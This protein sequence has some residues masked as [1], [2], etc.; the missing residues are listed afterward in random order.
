M[1]N[2]R[3]NMRKFVIMLLSLCLLLCAAGCKNEPAVPSTEPS[4][5]QPVQTQ[6]PE[7]T[8]ETQPPMIIDLPLAAFSA[9][10]RTQSHYANDG[11]LL[12]TYAYQDFSLILEDPQVADAIVIDLLNYVDYE[13]DSIKGVLSDAEA[14]YNTATDFTPFTY[15]SFF[16]PERFDQSILSLYGVNA[17]H[18]GS[19]RTA[20]S[21]ISVTYD[22]L[23]GRQLTLKDILSED[24]SADTLS[25][26]LIDALQPMSE[27]GLL[28]SDYA[29]VVS[30]LFST[31]RPVD[32]WYL[33]NEALCFFFAPYEIAP[34]SSG[35]VVAE[36]PYA[37]LIGLLREEYFPLEATEHSGTAFMQ[38]F[39]EI[40]FEQF[41]AFAELTIDTSGVQ[42]VLF[43]N[44]CIQNL[45]LEFVSY[46]ADGTA[47]PEATV[48]AAP[49]LC[50]GDGIVLESAADT[51]ENL[52]L[53]YVANGETL[54]GKLPPISG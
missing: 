28:F 52:R 34:Y 30:E 40:D 8:E 49:F 29:Y 38:P 10:V 13:N 51:A 11:T 25:Q 37:S 3:C 12:F 44:G 33:T 21:G 2:K 1:D 9:P 45:R 41:D 26:L 15:S 7:T 23:N 36:V 17:L 20:T 53:T 35:T 19:P 27:E 46:T 24:Y 5:T 16:T 22:L 18:N 54:T 31:N 6:P 32:T 47:L 43:T 39:Q 50:V 42:H 14:A 48:F 4:Q